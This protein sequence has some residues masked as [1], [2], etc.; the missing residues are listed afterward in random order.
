MHQYIQFELK[1]SLDVTECCEKVRPLG[2]PR[3]QI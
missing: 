2:D 3:D 1:V